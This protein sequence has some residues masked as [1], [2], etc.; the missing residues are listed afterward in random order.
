VD[1]YDVYRFD[2]LNFSKEKKNPEQLL[3]MRCFRIT[4]AKKKYIKSEKKRK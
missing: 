2:I 3:A 4:A 1:Q